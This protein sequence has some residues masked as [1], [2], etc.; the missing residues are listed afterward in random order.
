[1][2]Q[3][4]HDESWYQLKHGLQVWVTNL[5]AKPPH[6]GVFNVS[7]SPREKEATAQATHRGDGYQTSLRKERV[8][9]KRAI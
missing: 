1:L 5:S 3:S 2:H 7:S 9:Y 8:C 4:C 6:K